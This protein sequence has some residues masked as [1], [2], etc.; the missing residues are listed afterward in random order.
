M[1]MAFAN[2][3]ILL[4][5]ASREIKRLGDLKIEICG[6]KSNISFLAQASRLCQIELSQQETF[7]P[8]RNLLKALLIPAPSLKAHQSQEKIFPRQKMKGKT[9][10]R[11]TTRTYR[12]SSCWELCGRKLPHNLPET[13]CA[14]NEL[15]GLKAMDV[16]RSKE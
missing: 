14:S 5:V 1:K 4:F 16:R 8:Q 2:C 13:P 12:E 11:N 15:P 3:N 10:G 7:H 6:P 9:K